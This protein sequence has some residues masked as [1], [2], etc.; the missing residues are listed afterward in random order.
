MTES[1]KPPRLFAGFCLAFALVFTA[2]GTWFVVAQLTSWEVAAG[3]VT[4]VVA[5]STKDDL[6]VSFDRPAGTPLSATVPADHGHTVGDQVRIRYVLGNDGSVANARL[7]D[8]W[9]SHLWIV[10]VG[11]LLTA[12][13]VAFNIFI[14]RPHF[15]RLLKPRGPASSSPGK[16]DDSH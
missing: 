5:K 16:T 11:C 7:A 2:I 4:S 10:F 3:T 13:G 9:K 14:R 8:A 6:V 12:V 15:P 1:T